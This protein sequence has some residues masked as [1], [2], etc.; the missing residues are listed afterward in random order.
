MMK[1]RCVIQRAAVGLALSLVVAACSESTPDPMPSANSGQTPA[2]L[3]VTDA[4]T[5][6][7][8]STRPAA[9]P[10]AT[11]TASA[12][13]APLPP[14][15]YRLPRQPWPGSGDLLQPLP[16]AP[17]I[18]SALASLP[19]GDYFATIDREGNA[20][21]Y[22]SL[23]GEL[24]GTL[25]A[26][27]PEVDPSWFLFDGSSGLLLVDLGKVS[28]FYNLREGNTWEVGP[29]C[30]MRTYVYLSPDRKWLAAEC[31]DVTIP[32][33]AEQ[34]TVIEVLSIDRG[35]GFRIAV[36]KTSFT[37]AVQLPLVSWLGSDVLGI[38]NVWIDEHYRTCAYHV[39]SEILYCPPIFE[40]DEDAPRFSS[41]SIDGR[42]FVGLIYGDPSWA[43]VM[44]PRDCFDVGVVC[45]G[46]IELEPNTVPYFTS[47]PGLI[48]WRNL[49]GPFEPTRVGVYEAPD[50]TS[51]Q[52]VRFSKD[53]ATISTCPDGSCMFLEDLDTDLQYRLDL[54]GQITPLHF[55]E[56][57]GAFSVP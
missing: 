15:T 26:V 8:T 53:F 35:V 48:W 16:D 10:T 41:S 49:L 29:V 12:T 57:I 3:S 40:T 17:V 30:T 42:K 4:N 47:N 50:W 43:S 54:N 34:H 51:R 1:M 2:G 36:P 23:D 19:P 13:P 52:V 37:N 9:S 27:E 21:G 55:G 6:A 44:V 5:P 32:G 33:V 7:V 20:I 22:V 18:G 24:E 45:E 11:A 14:N 28:W 25:L 31:E 56:I 38:S 39:T 46:V